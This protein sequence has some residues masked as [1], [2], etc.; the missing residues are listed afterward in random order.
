M[1]ASCNIFIERMVFTRV[2]T[3]VMFCS[4]PIGAWEFLRRLP[5]AAR[6]RRGRRHRSAPGLDCTGPLGRKSVA[7]PYGE[8]GFQEPRPPKLCRRPILPSRCSRLEHGRNWFGSATGRS[9]WEDSFGSAGASPSQIYSPSYNL[10][11]FSNFPE[12]SGYQPRCSGWPRRS[13]IQ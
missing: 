1:F 9:G 5:R 12:L 7:F 11:T 3:R 13:A 10:L 4:A 6:C 2:R 8:T